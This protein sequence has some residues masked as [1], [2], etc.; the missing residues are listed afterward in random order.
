[1]RSGDCDCGRTSEAEYQKLAEDR[2]LEARARAASVVTKPYLLRAAQ[3]SQPGVPEPSS[4]RSRPR[5]TRQPGGRRT[6]RPPSLRVLHTPVPASTTPRLRETSIEP[7]RSAPLAAI[8]ASAGVIADGG[9]CRSRQ[10]ERHCSVVGPRARRECKPATS[11]VVLDRTAV[12]IADRSGRHELHRPT[13]CVAD[14]EPQKHPS[15]PVQNPIRGRCH[16]LTIPHR[17]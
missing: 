11:N 8:S 3:A 12:P 6:R 13:E 4:R 15:R 7:S 17:V 9:R 14:R 5:W 1:M 16:H 10:C 2:T